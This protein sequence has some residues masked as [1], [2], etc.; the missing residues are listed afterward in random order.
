MSTIGAIFR[1][2]V[3][4]VAVYFIYVGSQLC[5]S[6]GY[7]T[8]TEP[9]VAA[10][11]GRVVTVAVTEKMGAKEIAQLFEK[12]GLTRDWKLFFLQYYASEFRED[13]KPGTYDLNTNMTAEQM[14]ECMTGVTTAE[15]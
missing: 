7:R 4:I 9:A 14:M 13:L 10:G 12:K 15:E 2:V 11:E 6:Y 1:V 3:I 5:Y 8:F